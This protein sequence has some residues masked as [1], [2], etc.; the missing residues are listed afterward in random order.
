MGASNREL[1]P[2]EPDWV[3]PQAFVARVGGA[4]IE[5]DFGMRWGERREQR[6]SLR[7]RP[8]AERGLLYA[9][10]PTWHEYATLADDV[11]EPAVEAAFA[12]ALDIDTQ[13]HVSAFAELVRCHQLLHTDA[14]RRTTPAAVMLR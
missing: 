14:A 5:H 4:D 2:P 8:G 9:Y 10:D 11:A 13:M 7:L 12:R 3:G 6:I 1:R